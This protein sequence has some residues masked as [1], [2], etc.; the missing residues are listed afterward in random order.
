MCKSRP[1]PAA[2]A[3]VTIGTPQDPSNTANRQAS[4]ATA[5]SGLRKRWDEVKSQSLLGAAPANAGTATPA[6]PTL[7]A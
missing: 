2:A 7:G 1:A 4:D 5:A 3:P 6:K